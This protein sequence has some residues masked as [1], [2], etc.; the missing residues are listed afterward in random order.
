MIRSFGK[1]YDQYIELNLEKK[2]ER[3]LFELEDL[4]ALTNAIFL[5]KRVSKNGTKLLFIDEIQESPKAIQLLRYFFEEKPEIHVIAAGS[6]L[7]FALKK[8]PSFPVGRVDYLYSHPFNFIE[9]LRA[10]G[11]CAGSS[12]SPCFPSCPACP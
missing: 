6:L 4:D 12:S 1:S 11:E 3:E 5:L 8:V 10:S 9:F 7:E 2:A